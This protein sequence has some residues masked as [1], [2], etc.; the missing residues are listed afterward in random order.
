M[1]SLLTLTGGGSLAFAILIDHPDTLR[2]SNQGRLGVGH[3]GSAPTY[4]STGTREGFRNRSLISV[5][6]PELG[7]LVISAYGE[8]PVGA[9]VPVLCST[10]LGRCETAEGVKGQVEMWPLTPIMITSWVQLA[11]AGALAIAVR[12]R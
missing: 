3:V 12:R 9:M 7:P 8:L 2:L 11:L 4:R 1:I 5:D 10:S 6:D